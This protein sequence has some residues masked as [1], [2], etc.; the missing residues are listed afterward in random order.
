MITFIT[1]LIKV[2]IC[3]GVLYSYYALALK[4]TPFHRW[5][6]Y[7]LLL[8]S[9]LSLGLPLLQISIPAFS[10][11]VTQ[12]YVSQLIT[13]REFIINGSHAPQP[14]SGLSFWL[15]SGYAVVALIIL[16]RLLFN[17]YQ[18][19][20]LA[21]NSN[22][23]E[24]NGYWLLENK[25]VQSPFSFFSNIFWS[26]D[27]LPE[28]EA[29]QQIL[30]HEMAHVNGHHTTD[31]LLME[32]ICAICWIN[33]FFYLLKQ[34]LCMIHEFIADKAAAE[35]ASAADYAHTLLQLSLQSKQPP[36]SNNFSQAPVKRRILMLFNHKSNHTIMKKTIALPVLALLVAA[37]SCQQKNDTAAPAQKQPAASTFSAVSDHKDTTVYTFVDE[38]PAF[39]G[40]E[41]ALISYL[42]KTVHYPKKA[43]NDSVQGTIFVQ[44]TVA[45]DGSINNVKT[46][47]KVAGS[48]LEEESIRVVKTMPNWIPGKMHGE[49]VSVQFNLPIRYTLKS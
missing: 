8:A 11:P 5:N 23:H 39:P 15:L 41:S 17:W 43:V 35:Q 21:L 9:L 19:K 46:V 20:R 45:G 4:N 22:I 28:S 38:P 7:F 24:A 37:V 33:P 18:L 44:F 14:F 40:G 47:G 25:Q 26:S 27:I 12:V 49:V 34:E 36:L 13:A 6:R 16:I 48:G 1:Y 32:T 10:K 30:K 3:S 42:S 29:G 31:K 2:F